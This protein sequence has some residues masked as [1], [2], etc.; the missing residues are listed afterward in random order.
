M[1][2]Q[3]LPIRKR[4][5]A[6]VAGGVLLAVIF[7]V[8]FV[9]AR[10]WD[11][12]A[13]LFPRGVSAIGFLLAVVLIVRAVFFPKA[14]VDDEPHEAEGPSVDDSLEYIFHTASLRQWLVT[15]AW[16]GGF[17]VALYV[18][19][20]YATAVVFALFY[21]RTQDKRSWLFCVTYAAVLTAVLYLA[22]S[23]LLA[24]PVPPG[25]FGIA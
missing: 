1:S 4:S 2:V 18:L 8:A 23:V 7:A 22:F 13:A 14:A 12:Q 3:Q 19:G 15:L 21:L 25:Y 5:Y 9:L 16:F 20:L 17:F 24:Q 6:D 10:D 11:R